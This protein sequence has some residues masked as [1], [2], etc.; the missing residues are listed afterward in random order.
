MRWTV[1]ETKKLAHLANEGRPNDEIAQEMQRST[2]SVKNKIAAMRDK[3][4]LPAQ[5]TP[6]KRKRE[7]EGDDRPSS[8]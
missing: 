5:A 7:N 6:L 3:G 8:T 1:S 2:S 4:E